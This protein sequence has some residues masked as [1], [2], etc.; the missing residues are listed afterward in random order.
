MF[1]AKRH[2][3][4]Q[5]MV[6]R[7]LLSAI[8]PVLLACIAVLSIAVRNAEKNM[9]TI[10]ENNLRS[11]REALQTVL[12]STQDI[13]LYM[14][15]EPNII[16][17]LEASPA[18]DDYNIVVKNVR[19]ILSMF[20][21]SSSYYQSITLLSQDGRIIQSGANPT[22]I[23]PEWIRAADEAMGHYIWHTDGER[24]N[25]VYMCRQ[26]RVPE[27]L[28]IS[29]GY[30]QVMISLETLSA[31]LPIPINQP[32]ITYFLADEFDRVFFSSRST[33]AED[34]E[35]VNTLLQTTQDTFHLEPDKNQIAVSCKIDETGWRLISI[36]PYSYLSST[37]RIIRQ[38]IWLSVVA[39]L[40]LCVLTTVHSVHTFVQPLKRL[41]EL[42]KG[43]SE[44]QFGVQLELPAYEEMRP[45]VIQFN[46]M[47]SRLKTLYHQNYLNQ[48]EIVRSELRM[49]ESQINP[50]F[51]F[52]TLDTIYW[53]AKSNQT[54]PACLMCTSLSGLLHITLS[55]ENKGMISLSQELIL[56]K[57]YLNI[58]QIRYGDALHVTL[59]IEP[60]LEELSVCKLVLQPIVENAIL[61][62]IDQTGE[63]DIHVCI[64][65]Q[66]ERLI[67]EISD[68]CAVADEEAIARALSGKAPTNGSH[69][70]ALFNINRR[71]QLVYGKE[72]GV[73]F[74]RL[75]QAS[76]FIVTMLR[77]PIEE[78]R[79]VSSCIN[80]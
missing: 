36:A 6:F 37:L 72:F 64:R 10:Y 71:I 34:R 56:L 21:T 50:H 23:L 15:V 20:S 69:G 9:E 25:S 58:Q 33:K 49:L 59:Q 48:L 52:N 39:S 66:G 2:S 74:R 55:R 26:L 68:S 35:Y 75:P 38:L 77:A 70:L 7:T 1:F 79:G 44:E 65:T 62:G 4:K 46:E 40:A 57:Y 13:S 22:P 45:L 30:L 8:L 27:N 53:T 41:T 17:Y 54:E 61:H 16:R 47:S 60:G 28:K 78:E 73:S 19:D 63:G 24:R 67:Y 29:R 32:E 80:S 12:H 43:L 51:L 14:S 11:A 3:L 76:L 5:E 42:M 31:A 18:N